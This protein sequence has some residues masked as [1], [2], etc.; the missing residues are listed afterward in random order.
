MG[1]VLKISLLLFS[2]PAT[3]GAVELAAG[4]DAIFGIEAGYLKTSGHP[5]WTEGFVGKLRYQDD[6]VVLN[7]AFLDYKGRLTDTLRAHVVLEGYDDDLGS[8]IDFTQAYLEWRPVP[9]SETRYRLKV[10]AFYPRISMENVDPGWSSRYTLNSSA[11]N[12]WVA[13][14]LRSTGAELTLSRRPASMGGAHTFSLNLAAFIG[15]DPAGSLLAWKGWSV[16]DRQSR[17]SDD[18]PLPPLPQIQPGRM[19]AAQDPYVEPFQEIDD[20]IGYYLNAEWRFGNKLLVRAMH[21]DNRAVPT[22]IEN[23]QYGWTTKFD[24]IGIQTTLPGDIGFVGQWMTGS[25]VMGPVMNGAHAVDVEYDSFFTLLTR[26]FDK[27][28]VTA[29]YDHFDITQND[30]TPE[31][32]NPENGH[33]WTLSYQYGFSDKMSLAAEWLSIKTHHC[34]WIYYGISPTETETQTQVTLRLRF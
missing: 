22:V 9:R 6:G 24:H 32:N 25:T 15:N 5:S 19:F 33:A 4:H 18:L 20:E 11:I 23:G 7:R 17:F 12:T 14:E 27:H 16:H 34:A 8:A 30:R 3:A 10:G 1:R 13:E 28:R 26:A 31:D 2:L 29:R 21:Y